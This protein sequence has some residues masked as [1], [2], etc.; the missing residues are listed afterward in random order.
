MKRSAQ[1]LARSVQGVKANSKP[2]PSKKRKTLQQH[3]RQRKKVAQERESL[4]CGKV[5]EDG[6]FEVGKIVGVRKKNSKREYLVR[7]KG[8]GPAED[9]WEPS[10]NLCDTAHQEAIKFLRQEAARQKRTHQGESF[11]C[12]DMGSKVQNVEMSPKAAQDKSEKEAAEATSSKEPT[13]LETDSAKLDDNDKGLVV[14]QEV[15]RMHVNHVDTSR[16]VNEA[17]INGI[18]IVLTGHCGWP[19]FATRWLKD[20]ESSEVELLDLSQ[21]HE[22]DIEA[23][24]KDIGEESVPILKK[25]Y[26]ESNPIQ[27]EVF[28]S[29]FLRKCWPVN[30][31]PAQMKNLYLH[32]WQFPMSDTAAGKLCGRGNCVPLPNDIFNEDLLQFWL[33][34]K[35]NPFQYIFMGDEGTMSKLH[36]DNG[37]LAITIAPIIGEKECVLAHRLDEGCLYNLDSKLDDIDLDK[38]PMTAF[39]RVWKTVIRP[40]EILVMPHST[41]HQCRN[42]TPC[43][44]YHRYVEKD[45]INKTCLC[46]TC[47]SKKY[48]VLNPFCTDSISTLSTCSL[49]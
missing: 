7:W 24:I 14:F 37:G 40:G 42:V 20:V 8:F 28:A 9:S 36:N 41:Y 21:P 29:T 22:L 27:K 18:P 38:F 6:Y 2:S 4:E 31:E 30:G 43:L 44:S 47:T 26:D 10:A 25:N 13:V 23:M 32:Q 3:R 5:V 17:R 16:R 48:F 15:E 39:A 45:D 35:D 33:D 46:C 49:L 11:L 12:M 34:R 1:R 19:Q